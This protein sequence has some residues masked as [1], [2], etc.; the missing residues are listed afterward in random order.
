MSSRCIGI[1]ETRGLAAAIQAAD[2]AVKTGNVRLIGYE[3]NGYDATVAVKIEGKVSAVKAAA[4][5]AAISSQTIKGG[6][7]GFMKYTV[8]P[9]L[10]EEVCKVL[11]DN[12]NTVGTELQIQSGRR[13]QGTGKRGKW[14]G[15]WDPKGCYIY[16]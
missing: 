6:W 3:Y 1:I 14:V 5:A 15:L 10:K 12:K 9:A 8:R 13:P 4:Q 2:T 7:G 11:V 16:E